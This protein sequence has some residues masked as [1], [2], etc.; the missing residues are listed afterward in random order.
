MVYVPNAT[1]AARK[2]ER[3]QAPIYY[4]AVDGLTR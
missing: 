1:W 2:A 4:I 3:E